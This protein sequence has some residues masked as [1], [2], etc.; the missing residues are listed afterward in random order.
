MFGSAKLKNNVPDA[1]LLLNDRG[2]A[3]RQISDELDVDITKSCVCAYNFS[4][5]IIAGNIAFLLISIINEANLLENI[6]DLDWFWAAI[7]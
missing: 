4:L 1:F 7:L 5:F 2:R 3:P 6:N